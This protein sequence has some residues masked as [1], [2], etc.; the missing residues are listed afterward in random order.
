MFTHIHNDIKYKELKHTYTI[1]ES[2]EG[3]GYQ[4]KHV[5]TGDIKELVFI[6]VGALNKHALREG[7]AIQ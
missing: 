2:V 7:F 4:L 1:V 3:N 6:S 5:V